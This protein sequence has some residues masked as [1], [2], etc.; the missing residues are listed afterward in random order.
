MLVI[1]RRAGQSL[2]IGDS[3]EI[4]ITE[5]GPSKVT[6]AI[7][8]PRDIP[9]T[10]SEIVLTRNQNIA[11]ADAATADSLAKLASALRLR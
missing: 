10:R 4:Q 9:V 11:A 1:R 2:L 7:A 3:I 8:A 5:V 6:L